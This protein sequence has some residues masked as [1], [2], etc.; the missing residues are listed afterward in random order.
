M[1]SPQI[2]CLL[3]SCKDI[4]SSAS[5]H[6]VYCNIVRDTGQPELP[7]EFIKVEKVEK[8]RKKVEKKN[9]LQSSSHGEIGY[10]VLFPEFIVKYDKKK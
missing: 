6:W 2:F 9:N 7:N 1:L 8:S 3:C 10:F 4:P 5:I